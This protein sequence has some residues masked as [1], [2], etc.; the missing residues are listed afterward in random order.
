M[1]IIRTK[2]PRAN[3]FVD[4]TFSTFCPD[5]LLPITLAVSQIVFVVLLATINTPSLP[6]PATMFV[7]DCP[8][9]EDADDMKVRIKSKSSGMFCGHRNPLWHPKDST[10]MLIWFDS[11][12]LVS[13][14]NADQLMAALT[15]GLAASHLMG[16]S[17]NPSQ[18]SR[19]SPSPKVQLT[20]QRAH[21][22]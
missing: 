22:A 5:G 1:A 18:P 10:R 12:M 21:S 9:M 2:S 13:T 16:D 17:P 8:Q 7:V 4:E 15:D 3:P 6:V 20:P 11:F 14:L 19:Y